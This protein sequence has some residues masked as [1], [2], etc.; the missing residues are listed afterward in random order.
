[1]KGQAD[2]GRTAGEPLYDDDF[3]KRLCEP[4]SPDFGPIT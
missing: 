4:V 3:E 1:M 2:I